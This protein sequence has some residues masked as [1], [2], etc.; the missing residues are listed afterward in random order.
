MN[1]K[2][3]IKVLDL[4]KELEEQAS[5]VFSYEVALKALFKQLADESAKNVREMRHLWKEAEARMGDKYSDMDPRK[6]SFNHSVGKFAQLSVLN[7]K[8]RDEVLSDE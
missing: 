1:E 7:S 3:M 8:Y 6:I 5:L 2:D 4:G